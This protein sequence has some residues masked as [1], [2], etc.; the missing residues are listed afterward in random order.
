MHVADGVGREDLGFLKN[1]HWESLCES[2]KVTFGEVQVLCAVSFSIPEVSSL[3][4]LHLFKN[5]QPLKLVL[6]S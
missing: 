3:H 2:L 1:G 5:L 6:D 4:Q